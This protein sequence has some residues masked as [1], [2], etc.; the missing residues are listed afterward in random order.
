MIMHKGGWG[1]GGGGVVLKMSWL[2]Y[3]IIHGMVSKQNVYIYIYIFNVKKIIQ[4][5]ELFSRP[6]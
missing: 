4:K 6:S 3:N 5:I 2:A 1:G